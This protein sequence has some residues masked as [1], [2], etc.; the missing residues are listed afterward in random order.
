MWARGFGRASFALTRCFKPRANSAE[1]SPRAYPPI[2]YPPPSVLGGSGW[3]FGRS[4]L[5]RGPTNERDLL[6]PRRIGRAPGANFRII[7][8]CF[9]HDSSFVGIHRFKLQRASGNPHPFG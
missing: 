8:E 7:L 9:V 6:D 1:V 4:L 2:P 5:F 3:L